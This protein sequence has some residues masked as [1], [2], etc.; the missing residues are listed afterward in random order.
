LETFNIFAPD[1][2]PGRAS[3]KGH[4]DFER[5]TSQDGASALPEHLAVVE[6][7]RNQPL[8]PLE[9]PGDDGLQLDSFFSVEPFLLADMIDEARDIRRSGDMDLRFI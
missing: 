3:V 7:P 5:G 1:K 4:D 2:K 6:A 8:D 9:H